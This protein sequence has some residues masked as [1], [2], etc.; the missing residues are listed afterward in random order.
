VSV[1]EFFQFR[2][3]IK[4]TWSQDNA[5]AHTSAQAPAAIQN[6]SF[7][8]LHHPPYSQFVF[9]LHGNWLA[10]RPRTTGLSSG[11]RALERCWTKCISV[12]GDYVEK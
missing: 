9:V 3:Q 2:K 11:I 1:H 5:P 7:E 6:A 4:V 8:L 10:V 12:A